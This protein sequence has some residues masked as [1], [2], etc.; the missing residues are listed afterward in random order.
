LLHNNDN[1]LVLID[2]EYKHK[3]IKIV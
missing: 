1:D 2:V 3:E